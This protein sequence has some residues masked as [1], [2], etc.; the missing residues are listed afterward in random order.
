MTEQ[1]EKSYLQLH[2]DDF[3]MGSTSKK[4]FLNVGSFLHKKFNAKF[5]NVVSKFVSA[6]LGMFSWNHQA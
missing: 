4:L 1:N 5:T 3:F 2:V 6:K